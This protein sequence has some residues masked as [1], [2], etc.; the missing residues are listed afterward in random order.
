M[1]ERSVRSLVSLQD[2][3]STA[4]VMNLVHIWRKYQA[5]PEYHESPLFQHPLLN[6]SIIVKH[7]LREHELDL[8]SDGRTT[9]TKILLPLDA[10][11]LR[12]GGKYV[13]INQKKYELILE[14]TFGQALNAT[15]RDRIVLDIMDT[16]PSLDPF[17]L[18]EQMKRFEITP[19]EVYFEISKADIERMHAFAT[20]EVRLLVNMSFGGSNDTMGRAEK[21]VSKILSNIVD[22]E[23]EHL[24]VN[25]QIQPLEFAS[26]LFCWRG[27]LYYKWSHFAAMSEINTVLR[28]IA[29]YTPPGPYD[30]ET[31][32]FL[33]KSRA[34]LTRGMIGTIAEIE[35][36]LKNY[37]DA[38]KSLTSQRNPQAFRQFLLTAPSIFHELGERLGVISHIISYWSFRYPTGKRPLLSAAD[39]MRVFQDFEDSLSFTDR[40]KTVSWSA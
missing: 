15:S 11:D 2:S 19:S 34:A 1:N 14:G 35:G 12:F 37:D 7:R 4:R 24:R 30:N 22:G 8:F 25:L 20:R 16:T 17:L 21:L 31:R 18:R 33:A 5:N 26:S 10:R 3:A 23:L 38:Y 39:L 13:F 40:A 6:K 32:D 29:T 36:I 9:G 27:F 28:Q